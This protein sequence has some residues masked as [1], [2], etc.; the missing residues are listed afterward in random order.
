MVLDVNF[1]IS[2][3]LVLRKPSYKP[4]NFNLDE[5]TAEWTNKWTNTVSSWGASCFAR[6]PKKCKKFG[7]LTI[8]N[9]FTWICSQLDYDFF[10]VPNDFLK[11]NIETF[12]LEELNISVKYFNFSHQYLTLFSITIHINIKY[13]TWNPIFFWIFTFFINI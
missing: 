6:S 12:I 5:G 3:Q 9:G 11:V 7:L 13:S 10:N 8:K 4:L 2:M 1:K